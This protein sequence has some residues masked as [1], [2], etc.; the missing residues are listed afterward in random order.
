VLSNRKFRDR[1]GKVVLLDARDYWKK[2]RKSLGDKRK[3]TGRAAHA[4]ITRLYTEALAVLDAAEK[5]GGHDLADRAGR[6]RSS[7]NEDLGTAGSP[8]ERPLKLRFEVTDETLAAIAESKPI[9]KATDVEAF[10][11]G[12]TATDRKSWSTK[13]RRVDST[14]RTRCG[15]RPV[16]ANGCAFR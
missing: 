11:G 9:A 5:G 14:S 4:E 8:V 15:G 2:M 3:E 6:S 13:V 10:R 7:K 12:A 1:R 16:V